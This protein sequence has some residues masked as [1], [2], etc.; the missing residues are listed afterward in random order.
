MHVVLAARPENGFALRHCRQQL[1]GLTA[2]EQIRKQ[3]K[4]K[5]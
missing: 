3:R 5:V 1:A 4:G 2:R